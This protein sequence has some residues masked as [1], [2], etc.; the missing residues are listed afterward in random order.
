MAIFSHKGLKDMSLKEF[1]S[2]HLTVKI[3][4]GKPRKERIKLLTKTYNELSRL[5]KKDGKGKSVRGIRK[6]SK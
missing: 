2:L 4:V 6:A 3:H 5:A 1:I